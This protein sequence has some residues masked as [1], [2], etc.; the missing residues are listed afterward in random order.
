MH[1]TCCLTVLEIKCEQQYNNHG[2]ASI[3]VI[4]SLWGKYRQ[5]GKLCHLVHMLPSEK[6]WYSIS[7][8]VNYIAFS[9]TLHDISFLLTSLAALTVI[10]LCNDCIGA[11]VEQISVKFSS[12]FPGW[13]V[14]SNMAHIYCAFA[15]KFWEPNRMLAALAY[16][17]L[18]CHLISYYLDFCVGSKV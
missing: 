14:R 16:L 3:S 11:E 15:V 8:R 13:L 6:P 12:G 1:V 7:E 2:C 18:A 5:V 4:C 9:W 10:C 17:L